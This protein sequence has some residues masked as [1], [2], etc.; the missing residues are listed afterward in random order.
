MKDLSRLVQLYLSG[1][2]QSNVAKILGIH[3]STV[4]KYLLDLKVPLRERSGKSQ[5]KDAEILRLSREGLSREKISAKL[6]VSEYLVALVQ[7]RNDFTPK[8]QRKPPSE[9]EVKIIA[10][11]QRGASWKEIQFELGITPDIVSRALRRN[12]VPR[13]CNSK[14]VQ[15]RVIPQEDVRR[16]IN[17]GLSG[18]EIRENLKVSRGVLSRSLREQ[19]TSISVMQAERREAAIDEAEVLYKQGLSLRKISKQ[20][21][22]P[23]HTLYLAFLKRQV[24][25]RKSGGRPKKTAITM[26]NSEV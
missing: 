13:R 15:G 3:P 23:D 1:Y 6:G 17:A 25:F 5:D 12:S 8:R 21:K 16:A 22:V 18:S 24:K 7:Q 19:G 10:L 26:Q 20:V 2:T 4:R 14:C 11:Y 9:Q